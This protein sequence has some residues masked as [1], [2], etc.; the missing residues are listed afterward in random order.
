MKI[1][2]IGAIGAERPAVI[3]GNEVIFVDSLIKD[4]DR[5]SL[6]NGAY[7]KVATADLGTL[8]RTP[9]T[10]LRYGAVINKPTKIICVGLNYLL[11]IKESGADTPPEPVI[12][13]K[14]I[15]I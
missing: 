6:E 11:H 13:M 12:F 1:A 10:G 7:Q 3:D 14:P 5:E 8:E 2:R 15:K 4:W 9:L